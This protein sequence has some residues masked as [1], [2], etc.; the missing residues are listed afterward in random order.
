MSTHDTIMTPT[1]LVKIKVGHDYFAVPVDVAL[2]LSRGRVEHDYEAGMNTLRR[3]A[4]ARFEME[5][6]DA[7]DILPARE[8]VLRP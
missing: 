2:V 5:F 6:V 8:Q 3:V 1:D 7:R 4:P